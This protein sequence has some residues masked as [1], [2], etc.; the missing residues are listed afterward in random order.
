MEKLTEK[1]ETLNQEIVQRINDLIKTKGVE[2]VHNSDMVLSIKDNEQMYNLD[3]ARWLVELNAE[4]LI[5]N[6]GYT[7]SLDNLELEN[8]CILIDSLS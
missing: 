1:L 2:S 8:L 3:G 5:D 4:V 6:K 7:Y